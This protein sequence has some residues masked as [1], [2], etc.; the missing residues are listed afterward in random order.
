MKKR[1][2]SVAFKVRRQLD[3]EEK[4]LHNLK[5]T[6]REYY[7][8]CIKFAC[9]LVFLQVNERASVNIIG[10]NAPEWAIAFF[11]T[12]MGNF[13]P[14]GVYPTNGTEACLYQADHSEAEVI[15]VENEEHLIKYLKVL[16]QLPRIK[17]IVIYN[18][19]IT[20]IRQ[21]Y[22]KN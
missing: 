12:I 6:W 4:K 2:D 14:S 19:D 7:K 9:S 11:G 8:D 1:P 10:F 21:K 18:D 3:I 17:K 15:V 20:R 5:W 16:E 13:I 22:M